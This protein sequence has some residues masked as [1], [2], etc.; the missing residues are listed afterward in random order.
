MIVDTT[1]GSAVLES[2][3][4]N[5][6]FDCFR[7]GKDRISIWQQG[8]PTKASSDDSMDLLINRARTSKRM[9]DAGF[10]PTNSTKNASCLH[11]HWPDSATLAHSLLCA[12]DDGRF[13]RLETRQLC[14][15]WLETSL[16]RTS[17]GRIIYS[18]TP[19]FRTHSTKSASLDI[20]LSPHDP[21]VAGSPEGI[22]Q[23]QT[24]VTIPGRA[25][26]GDTFRP[27]PRAV[28]SSSRRN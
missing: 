27:G 19:V 23:R 17:T 5:V 11:R 20:V 13:A 18:S 28:R 4:I 6:Y 1:P 22:F 21:S 16:P 2:T 26:N 14:H 9:R 3:N 24:Y 10:E 25:N 15:P 8:R 7:L 12:Y